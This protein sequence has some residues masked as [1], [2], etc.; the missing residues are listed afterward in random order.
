MKTLTDLLNLVT[1]E[2][3][4]NSRGYY[5]NFAFEID[6]RYNWIS[7]SKISPVFS[8][9]E[10][11]TDSDGIERAKETDKTVEVIVERADLKDKGEIQQAYWT[12]Y[13]NGRVKTN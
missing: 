8:E 13:N 10:T 4:I 11:H 6:T 3:E 5:V 12:I 1:Q 2:I 9:T 7:F